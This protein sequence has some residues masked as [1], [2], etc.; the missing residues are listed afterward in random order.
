MSDS[1]TIL[2]DPEALDLVGVSASADLIILS[3][4]TT[5]RKARCPV[6]GKPSGRVHSRYTRTL[7]DQI[8]ELKAFA[9]KLPQDTDAVVAAM[10]LPYSQG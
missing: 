6:C 8:A 1:R 2:P 9:V 4:K 5:S 3:A 10:V 7:A